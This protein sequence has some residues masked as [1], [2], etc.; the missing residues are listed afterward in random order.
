[1]KL[2]WKREPRERG[3][4]RPRGATLSVDGVEVGHVSS[5]HVGGWDPVHQHGGWYSACATNEALGIAYRNTC[6]EPV[7]DLEEAKVALKA[8]VLEQ[9]KS[10]R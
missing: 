5:L 3:S 2:T 7:E 1:M 6:R 9:M 10:K 4:I 8:Y